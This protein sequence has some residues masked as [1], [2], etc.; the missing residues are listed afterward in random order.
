L[1]HDLYP[2]VFLKMFIP[3]VLKCEINFLLPCVLGFV[4]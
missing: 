2:H 3:F 4:A 1:N